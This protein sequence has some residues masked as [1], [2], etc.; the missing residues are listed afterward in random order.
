[1]TLLMCVISEKAFKKG[2]NSFCP[3]ELNASEFLTFLVQ[4]RQAD[5]RCIPHSFSPFPTFSPLNIPHCSTFPP[6]PTFSPLN[7]RSL[8][9]AFSS[10][11]PPLIFS[12]PPNLHFHVHHPLRSVKYLKTFPHFHHPHRSAK[13]LKTFPQ[14]HH[15]LR[16]V[17]Y[18]E[19]F[20]TLSFHLYI[21]SQLSWANDFSLCAFL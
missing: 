14:F 20:H 18:L 9:S 3:V 7:N 19:T 11:Q 6:F 2:W 4:W 21:I 12:F 10:N 5:I 17:K 16:S 8:I 1:M 15:P 13:Y